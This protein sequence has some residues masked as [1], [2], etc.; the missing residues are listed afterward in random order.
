MSWGC[1]GFIVSILPAAL[2]PYSDLSPL[3]LPL[4][5]PLVG[6]SRFHIPFQA[7]HISP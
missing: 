3:I 4:H 6:S 7:N 2:V 5:T 1:L